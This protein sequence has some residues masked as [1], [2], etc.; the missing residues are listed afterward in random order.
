MRKKHESCMKKMVKF[1]AACLMGLALMAGS[2]LAEETCISS[3]TGETVPVSIGRRRPAAVMFN[4][5]VDAIP[6]YGISK[7]G[8]TIEAEVE[9]LITRIMGIMEDYDDAGRIGSVRSARNY[10]YYFAREYNA[11]YCHYGQCP[12]AL[13]LLYLDSTLRLSSGELG[14]QEEIM[15]Y[16]AP[17]RVPPHDVFFDWQRFQNAVAEKDFD[18]DL[19]GDYDRSGNFAEEEYTPDGVTAH[20]VLPGYGFNHARFEYNVEDH[21][22]YRFQYGDP[23]I[24]ADNGQQLS[25][26]NIILQYCDS[27][28]FDDNGYLWTDV[29]TGGPGKFITNG[30]AID[31]T[32]KKSVSKEDSTFIVDINTPNVTVP[33]YTGDF[34]ETMYYDMNGDPIKLNRGNTWICLIRNSAADKVVISDDYSIPSDISDGY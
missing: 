19:P 8:V 22:Y 31:I 3:L 7:A 21:R 13:P 23:H 16:R 29:T 14:D 26:K 2:A 10:Y 4:N 11:V 24:D 1:V 20:I 28:P 27:Q 15:Y 18:M 30:K 6:Q 25:C 12:Y 32:W 9:G 17:D 5:I 34:S 33:L